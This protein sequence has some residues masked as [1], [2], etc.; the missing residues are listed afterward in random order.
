MTFSR[1][2][3]NIND[4]ISIQIP[5]QF[6]G[7]KKILITINDI[8]VEFEKKIAL[9][10]EAINDKMFIDDLKEVNE[11]FDAINNENLK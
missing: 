10:K 8:N 7:K 4:T 5:K 3:S 6:K 11:D 1:V 9:M 2:Y